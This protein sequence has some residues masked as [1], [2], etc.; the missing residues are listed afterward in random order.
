MR[1]VL[2]ASAFVL[3]ACTLEPEA[4][5]VQPNSD[6][7]VAREAK[8]TASV[9]TTASQPAEAQEI[10]ETAAVTA[11][12][13]E[14]EAEQPEFVTAGTPIPSDVVEQRVREVFAAYPEMVYVAWCESRWRHT[15]PDGTVLRGQIDRDDT[16]VM[17]INLRYHLQ[18]AL[19]KGKDVE[20]LEG[21][22]A[23]ALYLRQTQ[24]TTPWNASRDCWR[25][26]LASN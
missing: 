9:P 10:T 20:T 19:D 7:V 11:A 26:R 24:G 6:E 14:P 17:Q 13:K 4:H 21:N 1:I 16:G 12:T 18:T 15:N 22:L 25:P 2:L 5:L 23:Y 8:T 3:S